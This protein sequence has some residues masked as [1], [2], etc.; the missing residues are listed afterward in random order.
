MATI[1]NLF[2]NVGASTEGLERGMQ[3]AK[4]SVKSFHSEVMGALSKV[5]GADAVLGPLSS[6]IS[7]VE[8]ATQRVETMSKTMKSASEM[9]D[10]LT[11][12]TEKATK[13]QGDLNAGAK[14]TRMLFQKQ[15]IEG[16]MSRM[17]AKLSVAADEYRKAQQAVGKAKTD[18]GVAAALQREQAALGKLNGMMRERARLEG[19]HRSMSSKVG[20]AGAV[21]ESRGVKI[22]ADGGIDMKKLTDRAAKAH[23][24]VAGLKD[25]IKTAVSTV[26]EFA[27]ISVTSGLGLGILAGGAIAAVGAMIALTVSS[28][29]AAEELKNQ[30]VALG[31]TATRLQAL[32]DTYGNLGI[33]SGLAENTMQRFAIAVGEAAE[34]GKEAQDKFARIGLDST[35]LAAMDSADAFDTVI[36]RIRQMGTQAEKMKTLRDLFGRGGTGLA[37]AVNATAEE[38]SKAQAT[39][40][41][42]ELPNTMYMELAATSGRVTELGRAFENVMTMLASAFAPVVDLITESLT[43]M[44]TQDTDSL[45]QGMQTIALVMAAIYDVIAMA[46]NRLRQFWNYAQA[47]GGVL[48]ALGS[49]VVAAFLKPIESIVYAIEWLTGATHNISQTIGDAAT[50]AFNMTVEAAKAAGA[51]AMEGYQAGVDAVNF[52]GTK[53]VWENMNKADSAAKGAARSM[54]A[55]AGAAEIDRKKVEA[56]TKQMEDLR[57]KAA[58]AGMTEEQ[59]TTHGLMKTG[60][61]SIETGKAIAEARQLL[62][63]IKVAE[64]QAKM[65]DDL[66]DALEEQYKLTETADAYAYNTARAAGSSEEIADMLGKQAAQAEAIRKQNDALKETRSIMED[67]QRSTDEALMSDDERLIKKLQMNNA[68]ADTIKKAQSLLALKSSREATKSALADWGS[69]TKGLSDSMAEAT[70]SREEQ[71]RRMAAAA[72]KLGKDLDDAVANAMQ[73]E[74]AIAAAKKADE[75]RKGAVETLKNLQ[76]EVRKKQIGADAFERE[77]FAAAVGN[78]AAMLKQYDALKAQLGG[79]DAKD[80]AQGIVNS[81]DTAFGQM[82]I[83]QDTSGKILDQNVQQTELLKRIAGKEVAPGTLID[84]TALQSGAMASTGI[85][86]KAGGATGSSDLLATSNQYLSQIERN[87]RAFAGVLS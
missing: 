37:A 69:F 48:V 16:T 43:D 78:D 49:I 71:I 46:V 77:K 80:P 50:T 42:L 67:L 33:A 30:A 17:Q 26:K 57:E 28:A 38:F 44:M 65:K 76:D 61:N 34:G 8:K 19:E 24:A 85:V 39:A 60:A 54:V 70:S 40:K 9:Q 81:I 18:S 29:K 82:S 31:V 23:S 1:G 2:V 83:G 55:I 10:K 20:R 79:T 27:G 56:L 3:R 41:K 63:T 7:L 21:L 53:A 11:K 58:T 52:D 64:L 84:D 59:K 47:I 51:D 68:D 5:P 45:M 36:Q 66:K 25:K 6:I 75:D 32:R 72:G 4:S 74:S 35:A 12:A 13:A 15:D 86:G 62:T 73:M 87:T 14:Y 22:G